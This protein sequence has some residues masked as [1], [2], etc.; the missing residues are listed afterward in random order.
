MVQID[1]NGNPIFET[2]DMGKDKIVYLYLDNKTM[3]GYV[4]E[5]KDINFRDGRHKKYDIKYDAKYP[6]RSVLMNNADPVPLTDLLTQ[7]EAWF[8]EHSLYEKYK[9]KGYTMLQKPPHPNLWKRNKDKINNCKICDELGCN[10]TKERLEYI[11]AIHRVSKLCE[12]CQEPFYYDSIKHNHINLF[13]ERRFCSK[14]CASTGKIVSEETRKKLSK[15][16]KGDNNFLAKMTPDEYNEHCKNLSI[17][18]KGDNHYTKKMTP[19]EYDAYCNDISER[20]KGK[21]ISEDQK[22]KQSKAM[23]GKPAWNKDI[24][25][26]KGEDNGRAILTERKVQDIKYMLLTMTYHGAVVDIARIYGVKPSLIYDI[27][28]GRCWDYIKVRGGC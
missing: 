12:C 28:G 7:N 27:K 3:T 24:E 9:E 25:F 17:A 26:S 20:Q 23:K 1:L 6:G 8:I 4:G 2:V 10:F 13:N 22:K 5:T 21:I 19:E 15:A 11:M 16:N 18:H 14:R